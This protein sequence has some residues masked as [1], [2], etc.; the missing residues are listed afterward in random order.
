MEALTNSLYVEFL[1]GREPEFSEDAPAKS[2][3]R[4]AME[5]EEIWEEIRRCSGVLESGREGRKP[6]RRKGHRRGSLVGKEVKK[7]PRKQ[8]R[9]N[10]TA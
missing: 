10:T 4:H 5:E 2:L 7:R 1:V 3:A 9:R 8:K 6:R